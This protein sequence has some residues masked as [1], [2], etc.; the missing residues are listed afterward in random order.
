MQ[1]MGIF[2]RQG[3]T[4]AVVE[5]P[6]NLVIKFSLQKLLTFEIIGLV[7]RKINIILKR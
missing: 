2:G 1:K 6:S 7:D 4:Y 3:D 5:R